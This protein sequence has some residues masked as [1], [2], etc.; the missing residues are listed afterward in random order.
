M[1]H[2]QDM[3][4]RLPQFLK[5]LAGPYENHTVRC[6]SDEIFRSKKWTKNQLFLG[7]VRRRANPWNAYVRERLQVANEG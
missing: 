2:E 1:S 6:V 7:R 5:H 3:R 4:R